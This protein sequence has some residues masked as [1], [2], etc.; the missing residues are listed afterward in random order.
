MGQDIHSKKKEPRFVINRL[1][2]KWYKKFRLKWK[3]ASAAAHKAEFLLKQNKKSFA[4]IF[5]VAFVL[6]LVTGALFQNAYK[7]NILSPFGLHTFS[8]FDLFQFENTSQ[9]GWGMGFLLASFLFWVVTLLPILDLIL[10]DRHPTF[11]RYLSYTHDRRVFQLFKWFVLLV[12]LYVVPHSV[13]D[14]CVKQN[15]GYLPKASQVNENSNGDKPD[16]HGLKPAYITSQAVSETGSLQHLEKNAHFCAQMLHYKGD[17]LKLVRATRF[18]QKTFYIVL[19]G[20]LIVAI[21]YIAAGF[22]PAI[23]GIAHSVKN[24]FAQSFR[25]A[26]GNRF[27]LLLLGGILS[28][29]FN[30]GAKYYDPRGL[31]YHLAF[32]AFFAGILP[33]FLILLQQNWESGTEKKQLKT[34]KASR[35]LPKKH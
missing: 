32:V 15:C 18:M 4:V 13:N 9:W 6:Y 19:E 24:P 29:S 31:L 27:F 5:F 2:I 17:A 11:N 16:A 7:E 22:F 10:F 35:E 3:L 25:C 33:W 8:T 14:R 26:K 21:L 34:T 20:F 12:L 23:V 28:P 30:S 1:F